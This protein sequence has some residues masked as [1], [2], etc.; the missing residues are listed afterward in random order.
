M[1]MQKSLQDQWN[2]NGTCF[3]CGPANAQGLRLRSFPMEEGVI[4]DWHPEPHHNAY[5]GLLCGGIIGTLLDCHTGAA[6]GWALNVHDGTSH[7]SPLPHPFAITPW[8]TS[9][10]LVKLLRPAPTNAAVRLRAR[11]VRLD[12]D[13]AIV[14][15][16]LEATGK[17]CAT[18][19][20]TWRRLKRAYV[21]VA[22]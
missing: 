9:E 12:T 19:S 20:A 6:L 10:F 15:A 7:A 2:P 17:T 5:P 14:E 22:R 16:T 11:V 21:E 18:C 13:Q 3:G 4:A 1:A 8:A